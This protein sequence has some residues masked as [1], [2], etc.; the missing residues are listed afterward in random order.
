MLTWDAFTV[1]VDL[2]TNSPSNV[3]SYFQ[4]HYFAS[5]SE[6]RTICS[7]KLY[8][9]GSW[10]SRAASLPHPFD[11][12]SGA[13]SAYSFSPTFYFPGETQVT[14]T[15]KLTSRNGVSL[16]PCGI[17]SSTK[18]TFRID[19][20]RSNY[21]ALVTAKLVRLFQF[22]TWGPGKKHPRRPFSSLATS[23]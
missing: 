18:L 12:D 22:R 8:L 3:S 16:I 13:P 14:I 21:K 20:L 7:L 10:S 15:Q 6:R 5:Q 19:L 11:D 4:Y 2:W 23:L 9:L 17:S 1:L